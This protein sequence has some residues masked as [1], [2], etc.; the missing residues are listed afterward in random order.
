MHM[1]K[2][3]FHVAFLLAAATL[4]AASTSGGENDYSS[5]AS[6]IERFD[7]LFDRLVPHDAVLEKLAKGF[8]WAE[9][10]VWIKQAPN[11]G[12]LLFSDIPNNSIL[13]WKEGEAIQL[14]LKPSGYTGKKPR[15]GQMGSNGLTLDATGQLVLCQHGDR[16]VVKQ[17]PDGCWTTLVDHYEGRRFNS[18]NDSVFKSNGDFTSIP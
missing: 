14:F 17:E 13:K 2:H 4:A 6:A 5:T 10:P 9:G 3:R 11:A 1:K 16:R 12:Y 8:L 15:C 18:P 7:A